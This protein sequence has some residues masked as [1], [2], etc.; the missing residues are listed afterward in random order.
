MVTFSRQ[1][2]F[3]VDVSEYTHVFTY[4]SLRMMDELLPKLTKELPKGARLIS[5]DFDFKHKKPT[6]VI[7]LI[8]DKKNPLGKKLFVYEF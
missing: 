4:L 3:T 6:E 5:Y 1:D 8:R 2:F 7:E